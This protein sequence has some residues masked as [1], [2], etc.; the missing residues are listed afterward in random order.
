MKNKTVIHSVLH[1]QC[2]SC[3][4]ENMFLKPAYSKGFN[5]MHEKCPNCGQTLW[6]SGWESEGSSQ[7][8]STLQV[9]H[10][11]VVDSVYVERPKRVGK[12]RM[13]AH[14]ATG[15]FGAVY[16]GYDAP[17]DRSPGLLDTVSAEYESIC[18][19]PR[20]VGHVC[21][22]SDGGSR[23]RQR[24]KAVPAAVGDKTRATC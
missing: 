4:S 15:G 7:S 5:K 20:T 2:P 24:R 10:D 6:R 21:R 3:R 11:G 12:F 17:L 14:V 22:R 13:V 23:D 19:S 8:Q 16:K 1:Q 9:E 18:R